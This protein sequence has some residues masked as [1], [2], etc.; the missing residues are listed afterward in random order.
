[1]T[2]AI[3]L[4]AAW[5]TPAVWLGLSALI[6]D[7]GSDGLWIGL[8][9]V[10]APLIALTIGGQARE[11]SSAVA[12]R[13]PLFTV[14]IL[15]VTVGTLLCANIVLAGDV[16]A[17][18]GAPRWQGITVAAAAGW[19]L[20]AWR[21]ARRVLGFLL[22]L[23]LLA[24]S[25]PL[26]EA[27]R[28]T[29][30]GPLR[31][32]E[33]VASEDAFRFPPSSPWV[34]RGRDLRMA[35]GRAPIVFHEEHRITAPGG[36]I[37]RARTVDGR[38]VADLEWELTPGQS[39]TLRPGD[40][41][42]RSSA[43]RLRFEA[44]KRVPGAPRSGVAWA[45]AHPRTWPHRAALFLTLLVGAVAL[46]SSGVGARPVRREM[47]LIGGG[48]VVGFF[49]AQGWAVYSALGA[50]DVFLGGV[51]A[52]RLI[53]LPGLVIADSSWRRLLQFAL[54]VAGLAG[55]LLSSV[56]LRERVGALD[57]TGGGEIGY[58]LGLWAGVFG[59]AAVA[60]LWPV[61]PW[62][63]TI[64][65]LGGAGSALA[66]AALWPPRAERESAGTAAGLVGLALFAALALAGG[67]G[68]GSGLGATVLSYPAVVAAPAGACVLWVARRG[69]RR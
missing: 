40:E 1:M 44:G 35:R 67:L 39:V 66:P 12:E 14:V 65:A 30:T 26:L 60:S 55:F 36:G 33:R 5:L 43:L 3:G 32:W 2:P 51:T 59:V 46:L 7:L 34:T 52:E 15:L 68:G 28:A 62:W 8:A 63:L 38:R 16:A 27:V 21:G 18:L 42:E 9:V 23:A 49:W 61:D 41:I 25:T 50:P 10:C 17:W 56:A 54:L 69:A 53:E 47:A 57:R 19:I 22:L 31:A 64:L 11:G 29:G 48:L 24:V 45:E 13:E 20:T 58:D 4:L 37:L 6:L